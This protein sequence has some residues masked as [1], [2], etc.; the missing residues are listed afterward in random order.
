VANIP[1]LAL[2]L[3][4][5]S[6]IAQLAVLTLLLAKGHFRG[7]PLFTIY[8]ILN[9]CQ[10]GLLI[11]VYSR[12]FFDSHD[13]QVLFWFSEGITL[14]AQAFAA[15]EV[16]HRVLRPYRGIWGLAWRLL[17]ITSSAV[18]LYVAASAKQDPD[19]LLMITSRGFHLTFTVATVSCL[20]L[21]RFYEI[22]V[23]RVYKALLSGF[24]LFSCA[25]VI[26][27]TLLPILRARHNTHYSEIWNSLALAVFVVVQIVW[28]VALREPLAVSRDLAVL[29]ATYARISPQINVR[30]RALNELLCKF[31]KVEA[32]RS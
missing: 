2:G 26:A 14:I 19:W 27:D 16:L 15:T 7:L 18:V 9:L 24:C 17:T 13:A 30:L 23:Q 29:P 8:I 31:W 4:A 3:W 10:A 11:I 6:I 5:L 25:V 1:S 21:I 12:L 32:P 22:P 28:T 20:L